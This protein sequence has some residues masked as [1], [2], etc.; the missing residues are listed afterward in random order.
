MRRLD[1]NFGPSGRTYWPL[2]IGVMCFLA[3][4]MLWWRADLLSQRD[5][6]I[7]LHSGS[8]R[9]QGE[10]GG[11]SGANEGAG[12]ELRKISA[13]LRYPWGAVW[14]ALQQAQGTTV[15]LHLE[16]SAREPRLWRLTVQAP[17]NTSMLDYLRQLES[18]PAWRSVVLESEAQQV[19]TP[20]VG[21]A[22]VVFQLA[23]EWADES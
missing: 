6:L 8:S 7:L 10:A 20:G 17:D 2:A 1:I 14:A 3:V 19:T 9:G 16:P 15:I 23:L 11:A 22:G 21:G 13:S 18:M 12:K 4:L 5:A